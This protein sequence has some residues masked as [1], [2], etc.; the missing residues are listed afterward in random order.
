MK[1][2]SLLLSLLAFCFASQCF[3]QK[4]LDE[5]KV[6]TLD[7][8]DLQMSEYKGQVLLIVNTASRCGFTPQM[9]AL[10]KIHEKY[11]SQGLQ[12]LAFPSNDFKQDSGTTA[13]SVKFAQDNYKVTFPMFEKNAVTGDQKQPLYQ[14][15]TANSPNLIKSVQWNFEKFLVNRKGQVIEHYRSITKPDNSALLKKIEEL[16]AQSP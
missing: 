12:V 3:A 15:L 13:D 9:A 4:S 16:L 10:Q 5:V 8:K 6:R 2:F 14:Y 1:N 11:N 7:G